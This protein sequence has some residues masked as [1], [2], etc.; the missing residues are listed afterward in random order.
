[1]LSQM[2]QTV[3]STIILLSEAGGGRSTPISASG[4]CY[5]PHV[6]V[7]PEGPLLGVCFVGGPEL[8]APGTEATVLMALVYH[9]SVDYSAPAAGVHFQIVEGPRVVGT[10]MVIERLEVATG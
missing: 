10:G 7:G 4:C 2:Q 9:P 3:E 1:M 6:R 5:R 8:V